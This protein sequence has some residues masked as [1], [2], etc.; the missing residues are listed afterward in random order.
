MPDVI[1]ANHGG[2]KVAV[3]GK[4]DR[5]ASGPVGGNKVRVDGISCQNSDA[6]ASG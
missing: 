6:Y 3:P 5:N 1:A 4:L 2:D